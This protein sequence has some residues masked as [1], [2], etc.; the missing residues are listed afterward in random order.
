M[1]VNLPELHHPVTEG[2]NVALTCNIADGVPNQVRWLKDKN[3]LDEK[4]TILLL[5]DIKKE[6]EGTTPVKQLM[7]QA[8]QMTASKSSLI[9][10]FIKVMLI[11]INTLII[12]WLERTFY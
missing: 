6:Q 7:E 11:C 9:V 4:K 12:L 1:K 5:R 3:Y 10:R 2:D 8:L